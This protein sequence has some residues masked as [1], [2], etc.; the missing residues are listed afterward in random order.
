LWTD[1][2]ALDSVMRGVSS[3]ED[4]VAQV[5]GWLQ[6]PAEKRSELGSRF[7]EAVLRDHCGA[8]WKTKWLDPAVKALASPE[9]IRSDSN[10]AQPFESFVL[11][12]WT[13]KPIANS[14]WP[15]GMLA[16]GVIDSYDSAPLP[17]RVSGVFHSIR[18]LIFHRFGDGTTWRRISLFAWLVSSCLPDRVR[19]AP[20][21]MLGATLRKLGFRRQSTG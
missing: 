10:Y 15:S 5:R 2:P 9:Q 12:P 1:D 6:W 13:G 11:P 17:I 19:T 7:R 14:N 8:S 3:Q 16:A 20:R 21:R 4:Y 18:P